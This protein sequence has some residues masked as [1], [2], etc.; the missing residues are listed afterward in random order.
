MVKEFGRFDYE[1]LGK[2]QTKLKQY[3]LKMKSLDGLGLKVF[4]GLIKVN[5]FGER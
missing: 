1:I 4:W 5:E 3:L 2:H